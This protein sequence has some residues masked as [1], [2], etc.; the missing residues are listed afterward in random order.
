MNKKLEIWIRENRRKL[1]S[2]RPKAERFLLEKLPR[3]YKK[4]AKI[5][6]PV[7]VNDH[8]YFI[9][10][11]LPSIQ[12]AIEVD[13]WSHADRQEK[14]K[15]RDKEL[16]GLNIKTL[17]ISN[18]EVFVDDIRNL[19]IDAIKDYPPI[20][21]L[22]IYGVGGTIDY[23]KENKDANKIPDKCIKALDKYLDDVLKEDKE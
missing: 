2:T 3:K 14:D 23:L 22:T 18:T 11:Y 17:R 10:I 13:G 4:S 7:V 16:L 8:V 1:I 19:L 15:I 20:K 5:Q 9:D 21:K 6:H 12:V